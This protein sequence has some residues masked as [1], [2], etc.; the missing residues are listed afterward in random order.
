M[1]EQEN[2]DAIF[3][4]RIGEVTFRLCR[5]MLARKVLWDDDTGFAVE[6]LAETLEA[7]FEVVSRALGALSAE[8][9][10]DFDASGEQPSLTERGVAAIRGQRRE[11]RAI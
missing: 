2:R 1:L 10:V 3:D 9:W 6:K 8:G 7:P 4:G 5:L 11:V